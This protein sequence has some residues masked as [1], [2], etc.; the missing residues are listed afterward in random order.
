M[1]RLRRTTDFEHLRE[2][3]DRIWEGVLDGSATLPGFCRPGIEPAVDI[4]E[5]DAHLVV[6]VELAGLRGGEL[7]LRIEGRELTIRGVKQEPS[8]PE[9]GRYAQMEIV[10]GP[11]ERTITLPSEA[12]AD[13]AKVEYANGYLELHLPRVHRH[14]V[15][16]LRVPVRRL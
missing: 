10:C 15:L 7:D 5:S 2:H 16:H 14:A 1:A 6:I 9:Y 12:T 13:G 8:R 11:F 4:L 3:M